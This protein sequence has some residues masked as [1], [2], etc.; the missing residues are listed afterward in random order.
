[1]VA[2]FRIALFLI[3]KPSEPLS[4]HQWAVVKHGKNKGLEAKSKPFVILGF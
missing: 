3:L 1:M 4:H 2:W